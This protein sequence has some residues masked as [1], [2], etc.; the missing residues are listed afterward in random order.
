MAVLCDGNRRWARENGFA[1]VSHGYRVGALRIAEL[2]SW[3]DAAGIE[4]ATIY[5]LSTENLQRDP[6]E[7]QSLIDI[8]T[9]VVE[10]ISGPDRNASVRIVGS[11]DLLPEDSSRRL[12]EAAARTKGRVGPHVNVAVGYGGRQ[13]IADAVKSLVSERQKDGLDGAGLIDSITV[14][15]IG[16]HLYTCLLYTSD[17]ADE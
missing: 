7:L 16:E 4:M 17:A 2:V 1:D 8:I 5:L 12:R 15:G 11:L 10:E 9:D 13:E 3:C 6:D 14:E